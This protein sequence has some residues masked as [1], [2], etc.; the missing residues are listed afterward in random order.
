M[1]GPYYDE[2]KGSAD[3]PRTAFVFAARGCGKSAYRVMIQRSCRPDNRDSPVLA[4]PYTDFSRVLAEAVKLYDN[5]IGQFPRN[6]IGFLIERTF[7]RNWALCSTKEM[8]FALY[9]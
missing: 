5:W 8:G 4:I 1:E 2:I 3:D 7:H 6:A 9:V